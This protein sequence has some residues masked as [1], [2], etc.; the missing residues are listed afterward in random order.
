MNT[1]HNDI[2]KFIPYGEALRGFADQKFI[3]AAEI[4]RILKERGIFTFNNN[5]DYT[6]PIM[7][8]LLLSPNE[9]DKVKDAFVQKEDSEKKISRE[10]K[11]NNDAQ[12]ST[13]ELLRKF[14]IELQSQVLV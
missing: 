7:Q 12:L 14:N 2:N 4:H 6:V 11:F 10:I 9:F 3:S 13:P 8:T 1:E 5:K